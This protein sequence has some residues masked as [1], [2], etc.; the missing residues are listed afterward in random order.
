MSY[1]MHEKVYKENLTLINGIKFTFREIDILACILHIRGDKKIADICNITTATVSTH[2]NNIKNK[3]GAN[4]KDQIIDFIEKSTFSQIFNKYY[5]ILRVKSHF[6][7][8]LLAIAKQI[9]TK[10][11]TIYC[12][13]NIHIDPALYKMITEHLAIANIKLSPSTTEANTIDLQSIKEESYYLNF[14]ALLSQIINEAKI[15]PIYLEFKSKYQILTSAYEEPILTEAHETSSPVHL[16]KHTNKKHI[17]ALVLLVLSV[18]YYLTNFFPSLQL[19]HQPNVAWE[20]PKQDHVFVPR[21]ALL[22][23]L[24]NQLHP[25]LSVVVCTGLGGVGKT[26]LALEYLHNTTHHYSLKAWFEAENVGELYTKYVQFAKAHGYNTSPHTREQIITFVKQWL[27][28]N[29]GWLIVYNNANNYDEIAPFLPERGG[30]IILTTRTREWPSNFKILPIDVMTEKEA[31]NT[32]AILSQRDISKERQ[33]MKELSELLG[34]LPLA[35]AQASAYIKHNNISVQEYLNIYKQ[36]ELQLLESDLFPAGGK[37]DPITVTWN[38]TLDA[39]TRE[40]VINNQSPIAIEL[41]TVCAYLSPDKISRQLMLAWLK[42]THP[43]I[44]DPE[45]VLNN[46]LGLL[47]KY[48]MIN[49][50][51]NEYVSIHRLVQKVICQHNLQQTIV[52]KKTLY[53]PFDLQWFT[54]LLQFFIEHENEFK[55]STSF[56][57]L[58]KVRDQFKQL[59]NNQY[60]DTMAELDLSMVAVYFYQEKYDEY[61]ARLNE[62]NE[63]LK[64]QTKADYLKCR[65]LYFYSAYY[66]QMGDY[67]KAEEMINKA[68]DKVNHLKIDSSLPSHKQKGLKAMVLYNKANLTF[69]KNKKLPLEKR[70]QKSLQ[71]ALDTLKEGI[72]LFNPEK[73]SRNLLRSIGLRGRVLA[74][75]DN[76]DQILQEFAQ[77]HQFMETTADDRTKMLFY[78]TYSDAYFIKKDFTHAK[79]YINKAKSLA[80]KLELT[81]EMESI[82][83]KEQNIDEAQASL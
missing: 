54:S 56:P 17:F 27:T 3:I 32:I 67:K 72:S 52:K 76:G 14:F 65:I 21:A 16:I 35:L 8:A 73:D 62:V 25:K 7:K 70:D 69:A 58:I 45:L 28:D 82:I 12:D 83:Q 13:S 31:I 60:N 79:S 51:Y 81:K 30:H 44:V 9:N 24:N 40:A 42:K 22:K 19:S 46:S 63:Y 61:F 64:T 47:W 29:P 10:P 11:I 77:H 34:Y 68:L 1:H 71:N 75:M 55:L 38:I 2:I 15:H 26:Q 37:H 23:Q 41:L 5:I 18:I 78:I 53:A 66:R 20:A 50:N 33:P 39:I 57:Q 6:E 49:Y 74:L 48:S 43:N 80:Q 59:F 36:N 4:S